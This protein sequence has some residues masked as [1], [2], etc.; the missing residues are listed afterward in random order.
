MKP[1]RAIACVVVILGAPV[2]AAAGPIMEY[3]PSPQDLDGLDHHWAY[4][5]G[6]DVT[7]PPGE[8]VIAAELVFDNIRNWNSAANVLY[9]HQL[10]ECDYGV[11]EYYDNQGGGDYFTQPP[12]RTAEH[13][14][15]YHNLPSTAQDITYTFTADDLVT[16][17]TY[18]ADGR[19]GLG[20]DPDCHFYN[21]G[22]TLRLE[23]PEPTSLALLGLGV[24]AMVRRRR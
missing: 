15:T 16:L 1:S 10:D 17:N 24:L 7:L 19:L 22:I 18:V 13:L 21:D 5:W 6:I 12:S 11:T 2:I 4:E 23:T 3:N 9:V 8:R 14:I 20:L